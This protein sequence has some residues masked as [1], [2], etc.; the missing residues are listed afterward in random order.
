[1][2]EDFVDILAR[3][4]Y[5]TLTV[6]SDAPSQRQR[7][8]MA[9]ALRG[10]HLVYAARL[11]REAK[12]T[13][14]KMYV[15]VGLPDEREDDITELI[16]LS[17]ELASYLPLALGIAPLVPKLHT[18]LGDA[19]FAGISAVDKTLDRLKRELGGVDLRSTSARWAWVEYRM[20]QG[21]EDAGLAAY[22]AWRR[23][24]RFADWKAELQGV[25]ERG[26]LE[27]A[28]RN[29]LFAPAGMR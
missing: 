3:G 6:A 14:L 1:M 15:I 13:R 22:R 23:G 9:K 16:E 19:P 25:D 27:A 5:R 28:R 10:K 4:G 7:D 26:G 12:M 21:A 17:R 24:G 11:A 29:A 2:D 20:S 18:P 8:Q